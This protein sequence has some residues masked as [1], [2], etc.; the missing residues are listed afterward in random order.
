MLNIY[1]LV[2]QLSWQSLFPRDLRKILDYP[3]RL[4]YLAIACHMLTFTPMPVT[5]HAN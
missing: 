4:S 3:R 2:R 5:H 1:C